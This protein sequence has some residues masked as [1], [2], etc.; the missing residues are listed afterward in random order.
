MDKAPETSAKFEL[1][2]SRQFQNWLKSENSSLIFTTYQVGKVFMLGV[3]VDGS[4]HVTERTFPRCMGLGTGSST[5]TYW[6]SSLFQLWRFENSLASG[7]YQDYDKVYLPQAAYTTGDLDIH[8]II[9]DN[10]GRPVFVNTL[11]SCL[12]TISETHSFKPIWKPPFISKLAPEDRCHMNGLAERDGKPAFVTIVGKSDVSD[13]WR[14]HRQH[15]GFLMDVQ[16]NETICEGLSMPH[17]PRWYKDKLYLLEAGTGYFGHVDTATGK[18]ERITFCPGFL[19]GL[20]FVGNYAIVGMSGLRKN[21]TFSGLQLDANLQEVNAQP[22]CGIQIINLET[23]A[24]E[25]WVRLEGMIEELYDVKVLRDVTRPLL[26]GTKKDEIR[27]M[28][29]V[30]E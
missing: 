21:K 23:G 9:I 5:N 20:D 6:M 22:R 19:R 4:L 10:S 2:T 7:K 11:F 29:S 16:T 24:V 13:G 15:G 26:I 1:S 18:F 25:H 12:A 28:I 3:N 30:E 8:D 17:S 27:T 14:D